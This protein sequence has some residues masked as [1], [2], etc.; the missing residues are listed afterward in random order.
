VQILLAKLESDPT[1]LR[2]FAPETPAWLNELCMALLRRDA[3]ARP[4]GEHVV[5]L[6]ERACRHAAGAIPPTLT[7]LTIQTDA[8]GA[9]KAPL[10]GRQRELGLLRKALADAQRGAAFAPLVPAMAPPPS[11]AAAPIGRVRAA[12]S[13]QSPSLAHA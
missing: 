7:D 2:E 9:A 10:V 3:L 8:Q 11:P 1:P 5:A 4:K 6:F 13:A 12:G